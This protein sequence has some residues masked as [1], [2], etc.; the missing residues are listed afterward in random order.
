MSIEMRGPRTQR[1]S[2]GTKLYICCCITK[3]GQIVIVSYTY[4][5]G[6]STD[7]KG[8]IDFT[9]MDNVASSRRIRSRGRVTFEPFSSWQKFTLEY[10][11]QFSNFWAEQCSSVMLINRTSEHFCIA[12]WMLPYRSAVNNKI[13]YLMIA[14][15]PKKFPNVTTGHCQ[16][17]L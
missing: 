3:R 17:D 5:S 9:S 1:S 14:S 12:R 15:L 11:A 2:S 8:L 13:P 4:T 10:T 7:S 16:Q 6:W